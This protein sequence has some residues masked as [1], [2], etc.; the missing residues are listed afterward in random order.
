[1]NG[2][3]EVTEFSTS[4]VYFKLIDIVNIFIY[5]KIL[6]DIINASKVMLIFCSRVECP[7]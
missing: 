7:V 2:A 3:K 5:S 4:F 6:E 1:M